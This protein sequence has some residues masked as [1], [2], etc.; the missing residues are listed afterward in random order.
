MKLVYVA[1]LLA[2]T[3]GTAYA[4]EWTSK[5]DKGLKVYDLQDGSVNINLVCD[6]A[7][8]WEPAE[9]HLV[10]QDA[11]TLLTGNSVQVRHGDQVVDLPL[12]AGTILST[13]QTAWNK[14]IE[15]ISEPGPVEFVAEK[16]VTFETQTGL[17]SA[18]KR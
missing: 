1:V 11:G 15:L 8:L 10:V 9:F 14:M 5:D 7:G 13:D 17:A 16:S 3:S 12:T 6:P 2:A 4:Q 18:C